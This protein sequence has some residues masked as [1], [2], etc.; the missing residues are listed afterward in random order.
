MRGMERIGS[1]LLSS[2]DNLG[3]RERIAYDAVRRDWHALCGQ[4]LSLHTFP[5]DLRS[6]IL[7]LNVDSPLWLR[8]VTLLKGELRGR[9]QAYD[10]VEVRSRLGRVSPKGR[11]EPADA[12]LAET[13]HG[14]TLSDE[15]LTWLTE[16]VSAVHDGDLKLVLRD[17]IA[18]ALKRPSRGHR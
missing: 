9:L 16:T 17:T 11:F 4:P 10:V 18:K 6:G 1:L 5:A 12:D 3:L 15:D 8:Q 14:R 2:F 13:A 7:T